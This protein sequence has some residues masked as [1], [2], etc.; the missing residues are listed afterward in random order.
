MSLPLYG[1]FSRCQFSRLLFACLNSSES[2][3]SSPFEG[4][5]EYSYSRRLV[6]DLNSFAVSLD[7]ESEKDSLL[8]LYRL[9]KNLSLTV[10]TTVDDRYCERERFVGGTGTSRSWV[11]VQ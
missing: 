4:S 3:N 2:V 6:A 8:D 1:E 10:Q 11:S 5:S 7:R 9:R